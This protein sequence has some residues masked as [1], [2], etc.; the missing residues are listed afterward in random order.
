MQVADSRSKLIIALVKVLGAMSG[1]RNFCAWREGWFE[2]NG[3]GSVEMASAKR[4]EEALNLIVSNIY[5]SKGLRISLE[6]RKLHPALLASQPYLSDAFFLTVDNCWCPEC[7]S[8]IR[9]QAFMYTAPQYAWRYIAHG[10]VISEY[11]KHRSTLSDVSSGYERPPSGTRSYVTNQV[12][13]CTELV[14]LFP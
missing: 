4:R 8:L 7:N 12:E 6:K 1:N 14:F 9:I 5:S 10:D 11:D 13:T 3:A 2:M